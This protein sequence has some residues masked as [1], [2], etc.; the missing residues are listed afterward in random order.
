MEGARAP[1][2]HVL[3]IRLLVHSVSR[4]PNS[5]NNGGKKVCTHPMKTCV[6]PLN[7]CAGF[8]FVYASMNAK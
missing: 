5:R 6:V 7:T 3:I 2:E 4:V 1:Y 8:D